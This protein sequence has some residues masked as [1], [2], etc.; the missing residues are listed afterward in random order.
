MWCESHPEDP[1]AAVDEAMVGMDLSPGTTREQ[2][3]AALGAKMG[4]EC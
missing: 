4:E 1:S 3:A 2:W